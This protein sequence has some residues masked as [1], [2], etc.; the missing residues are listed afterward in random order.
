[1][2]FGLVS[3]KLKVEN[4]GDI[5]EVTF[6]FSEAAPFDAEW[7]KYDEII[8]WYDYYATY[9]NDDLVTFSNN[10]R[11]VMLRF[12]DG[13]FGDADGVKNGVIVDPGGVGYDSP[14]SVP[15][16]G[17]ASFEGVGGCFIATAA[18]G[19][20]MEPGVKVLRDF[21][22]TYLVHTRIGRSFVNAY[23][24]YSPPIADY[25]AQHS[26]LKAVTKTGLVPVVV[27][28]YV[29]LHTTAM[30]IGMFFL[31]LAGVSLIAWLILQTS[32]RKA[33]RKMS[34]W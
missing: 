16:N 9:P 20:Y 4:A 7:F 27:I 6:Y 22:D 1:M 5:A 33:H 28:S 17:E 19:S 29:M 10:R 30:Q 13:G 21:R 3:F 18:Y 11:S 15:H 8:G 23:Y 12:K 34:N 26:I 25:I 31:L 2:P 32:R 14:S 24:R